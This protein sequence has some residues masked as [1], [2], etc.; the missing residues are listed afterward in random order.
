MRGHVLASGLYCDASLTRL[1]A[2]TYHELRL[3]RLRHVAIQ[4]A[5]RFF[6]MSHFKLLPFVIVVILPIVSITAQEQSGLLEDA[7]AVGESRSRYRTEQTFESNR[8]EGSGGVARFN[9]EI[10]PLLLRAC[11]SCHGPDEQEAGFRIDKLDPDLVNGQDESWWLEVWN[12]L[13]NKEMPPLD[14]DVNLLDP[15]RARLVQWLS[16]QIGEASRARRSEQNLSSFRRMTRYEY[17]YA[18]QDLFGLPYSFA[19]DLPPETP[20][21][22]GFHNSVEMLLMSASQVASYHELGRAALRKATVRGEQ[23]DSLYYAI[24][25]DVGRD[26]MLKGYHQAL[27]NVD[28]KLAD[29]KLTA[30][31]ATRQRDSLKKKHYSFSKNGAHFFNEQT[32]DGV[33][34]AYRYSGARY[35]WTPTSVPPKFPPEGNADVLILP[36]GTQQ[37]IDLGDH[38]QDEGTLRVRLRASRTTDQGKGWPDLAVSFGYQPSNN[39]HTNFR[40]GEDITIRA[41]PSDSQW[42]ELQIHL[43]E[44]SRNSYRGV[45]RLGVTPNPSEYLIFKNLNT[46]E[47]VGGIRI[48][49]MEITAPYNVQ[50]PPKSHL[51]VFP[52]RNAKEDET[53]YARRILTR[54]MKRAWRRDVTRTEVEQ[55]LEL[56]RTIEPICDD[57]QHAMTEVLATVLSSPKFLYLVQSP[58][59]QQG[60]SDFELATRLSIFLWASIPD[61]TLLDLASEGRLGEPEVLAQ[62]TNR[63]LN[64]P[65]AERFS[66]NFVR[67]WL[68]MERLD[69]LEIDQKTHR[70]IDSQLLAAMRREPIE[71]FRHMLKHNLSVVDFLHSD[72]VIANQSLAKHYAVADVLGNQFQKVQLTAEDRRGGLLTSAGLLAMNSDGKDTNPLKR[73]IWLLESILHDPPPPPPPAVPEIDLTDPEVLKMTLKERLADHRNDA[74]CKSCHARIDPWGIAFENYDA[75]GR[76]RDS[77]GGEPVDSTSILYNQERLKGVEGLKRY[78]LENRQDQFVRAMVHKMTAYALGRPLNFTDRAEVEGITEQVRRQGDGLAT[79]VLM[80]IRSDLFQTNGS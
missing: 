19:V 48:E 74:A 41:L 67:Q 27:V 43:G 54:F 55:K 58:A 42:Y 66:E 59:G 77:I 29:G 26:L 68:G 32:G 9:H 62:Q 30:E 23:P 3:F 8:D 63:M 65:R 5:S 76:W 64:D 2:S 36:P 79:L 14:S 60:L 72:Y 44:I 57:F 13:T 53:D 40:V 51:S 4:T 80:I 35:S 69:Y 75:V 61:E 1:P 25:M 12:V 20:S 47:D 39:S 7:R 45:T 52:G 33:R 50:W 18:L 24:S 16:D 71:L 21:E 15:E 78:L 34:G 22:D 31:Q 17:E 73:G 46:D 28:K 38:L 49:C 56:L 6:S 11:V 10:G 70:G 37:H